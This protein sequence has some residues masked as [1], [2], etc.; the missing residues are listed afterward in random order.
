MSLI[1]NVSGL[2]YLFSMTV[3]ERLMGICSH[4]KSK[5]QTLGN[6]K[7]QGKK[8]SSPSTSLTRMVAHTYESAVKEGMG[9]KFWEMPNEVIASSTSLKA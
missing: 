4:L 8:S 2:R 9:K 1:G 6:S 5:E 3:K 7:I